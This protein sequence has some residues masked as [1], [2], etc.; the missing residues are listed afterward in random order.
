MQPRGEQVIPSGVQIMPTLVNTCNSSHAILM[1]ELTACPGGSCSCLELAP[2]ILDGWSVYMATLHLHCTSLQTRV[3]MQMQA[4]MDKC[5]HQTDHHKAGS[6]IRV[7]AIHG[8][9]LSNS[10][11]SGGSCTACHLRHWC[12][13]HS[14]HHCRNYQDRPYHLRFD[15]M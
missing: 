12:H 10:A 6:C 1:E 5:R 13:C 3:V 9:L 4:L 7:A 15:T 11:N 2:V 8:W 14:R